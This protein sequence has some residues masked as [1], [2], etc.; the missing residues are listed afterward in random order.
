MKITSISDK[1]IE[2]RNRDSLGLRRGNTTK[3]VGDIGF[4]VADADVLR[5]AP[6]IQRTGSH[7]VRGMVVDPSLTDEFTWTPYN[8]EGFYYDIDDDVGTERLTATISNGNKIDDKEIIYT[9]SPQPMKFKFRDFGMYDVIGFMGDKYFAG[10]SN[11]TAFTDEASA[12]NDA[13]LRR[14]LLDSDDN[15]TIA[16]GSDL[17]LEEGYELRIKQVDLNGKMVYLALAKGGKEVDSEVVTASR[18]PKDRT[19]N[20]MYKVDL[21]SQNDVP[22]ITAHI[23]SISLRG[24]ESFVTVKGIFQISDSSVS[25]DEGKEWGILKV[26]TIGSDG[27]VMKNNGTISL[28]RGDVIVVMGNLRIEVADNARRLLATIATRT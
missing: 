28:V 12:I 27:I 14:V 6:M 18:D 16:N 8:F 19:S 20:Y 13:Q 22:I 24:N 21:D 17:P 10:Y 3:I 25:V 7:D 26:E 23:Q 4:R 5:F 11:L 2:M 9:T 1:F 15:H